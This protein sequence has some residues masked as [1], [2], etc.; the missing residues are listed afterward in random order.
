[1]FAGDQ[2]HRD[3]VEVGRPRRP[4]FNSGIARP[5]LKGTAS[6]GK[7]LCATGFPSCDTA[8]RTIAAA[9]IDSVPAALT[10]IVV[11]WDTP[12]ITRTRFMPLQA[13]GIS[14][15]F[16]SRPAP[17]APRRDAN[18]DCQM[19]GDRIRRGSPSRR[20][21]S[22]SNRR[23]PETGKVQARRSAGRRM[24][25]VWWSGDRRFRG[26]SP[27]AVA[28]QDRLKGRGPQGG[29]DRIQK[30]DMDRTRLEIMGLRELG[31][32]FFGDRSGGE[33]GGAAGTGF[34]PQ[35]ANPEAPARRRRGQ[36]QRHRRGA[37]TA[38]IDRVVE[39]AGPGRG[40]PHPGGRP[41]GKEGQPEALLFHV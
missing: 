10:R 31:A 38:A 12:S 19:P 37:E 1:M 18:G 7:S 20:V 35:S 40:G 41:Q 29:C 36:R 24:L 39:R 27:G 6:T 30:A 13:A 21:V 3:V 5:R 15:R 33:P 25:K 2:R 32:Q 34:A 11:S 17:W 26:R 23:P 14:T 8:T 16:Q 22:R 9:G 28:L 4:Q